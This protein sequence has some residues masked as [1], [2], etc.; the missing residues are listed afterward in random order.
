M[1]TFSSE[2]IKEIIV[3]EC[4]KS[5]VMSPAGLAFLNHEITI[6]PDIENASREE[7]VKWVKKV[8]DNIIGGYTTIGSEVELENF[9]ITAWD[10]VK[11]LAN[12]NSE[13]ADRLFKLPV[14][15]TLDENTS[16]VMD[17]TM[18]FAMGLYL[19]AKIINKEVSMIMY[20]T[21]L[22]YFNENKTDEYFKYDCDIDVGNILSNNGDDENCIQMVESDRKYFFFG[23]DFFQGILCIM[24]FF[25]VD[26]RDYITLLKFQ[27]KVVIPA[28]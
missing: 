2:E 10:L 21:P 20:D 22:T 5:F 4:G 6:N 9:T 25:Q 14:K 16:Y 7:I 12:D 13:D 11:A 8:I 3:N 1:A 15:I 27:G 17:M 18:D 23:E 19:A 26:Y 28:K 24:E